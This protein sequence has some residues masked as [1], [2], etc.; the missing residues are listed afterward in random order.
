MMHTTRATLAA[1]GLLLL[2]GPAGAQEDRSRVDICTAAAKVAAE[3]H[4]PRVV[5]AAYAVLARCPNGSA[6]LANAWA[7]PPADV[8]A[9]SQLTHRSIEVADRR[10]LDATL[11]TLQNTAA[12]ASARRAALDVVLS[13]HSP[14]V[15]VG[16]STWEDP[17]HTSLAHR[18]DYYQVPGEQPITAADRARI[19]DAFRAIRDSDPD[20]QLR[21]VAARI[22]SSL[23]PG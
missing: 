3:A 5:S 7:A 20:P 16:R 22:V 9:L 10:I 6:T 4:D 19:V 18:N 2:A 23:G 13:Q 14:A 8:E 17:E 1:L 21:K 11:L 12:S 15:V